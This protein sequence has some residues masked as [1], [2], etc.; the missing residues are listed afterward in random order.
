MTYNRLMARLVD[1]LARRQ[2]RVARPESSGVERTDTELRRLTE[3]GSLLRLAKGY[4][5]LVPEGRR[6]PNTAWRPTIEGAALGMAAALYGPDDVAL[7]GP[8]AVRAHGCYPRALGEGYVSTPGKLRARDTIVGTIRFVTREMSSMDTVR[9]ETDLG[10]GWAAS[11]E[12]TALDLCRDRPVWNITDEARTE[13]IRRLADRI[14]WDL[15]DDIAE[16]TRGVKTLH[17]LRTMLDRRR[18]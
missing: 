2:L 10:P 3:N 4:Y 1:E 6:S 16:A 13:M 17:R 8:S 11:V 7:V 14:D 18:P 9:V 5:V 12:Q 15:I